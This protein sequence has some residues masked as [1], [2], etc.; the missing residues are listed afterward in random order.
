MKLIMYVSH[1]VCRRNGA[2]IPVGL[3]DVF[4]VASETNKALCLTG[5]LTYRAG[6][7]LGVLEGNDI[8]VDQ[9]FKRI[10]RD[11]RHEHV[12]ILIDTPTG[13]R[14]FSDWHMKLSEKLSL[15][16]S[17]VSLISQHKESLEGLSSKT[18]DL[19]SHFYEFD[20]HDLPT[21]VSFRDKSLSLSAWPDFTS[22][23][24]TPMN[25][26]VCALLTSSPHT[27]EQVIET[28]R[29]ESEEKLNALLNAF[30]ALG[31]LDVVQQTDVP[32]VAKSESVASKF[33]SK[34]KQFLVVG[35]AG[36]L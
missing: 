21:T 14:Y 31:L 1:V 22:I 15:D 16:T 11:H 8:D 20:E 2:T 36:G 5:M 34:M 23:E 13:G 35:Y 6:H 28:V 32:Q 19:L 18:I 17:F 26:E 9:T 7:Y 25:I 3:S 30:N 4:R 12:E 29:C 33:Y 27:F 10:A 24:Q